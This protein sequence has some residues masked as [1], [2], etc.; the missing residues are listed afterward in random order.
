MKR[1]A[2]K[3]VAFILLLSFLSVAII[4]TIRISKRDTQFKATQ[5][6]LKMMLQVQASALNDGYFSWT[7]LRRLVEE[8]KMSEAQILLND[9]FEIYPFIK[10]ISIRRGDPPAKGYDIIGTDAALD[11]VFGLKDDYGFNPLPGWV[12]VASIKAQDLL[13]ALQSGRKLVVDPAKGHEL[14]YSLKADYED[15]LLNWLDYLFIITMTMAIGYSVSAW[16]WRKS[17]FFYE[18]KGLESIIFLFEQTEQL[19]ANHSRR[20]AVLTLYLGDKMGYKGRRL[21]NLYTAG[22]LHD[23]GKISVPSTLLLKNGPLT[24]SEQQAVAAHPIISARILK[25]FKELTHLSN[26]VLYH[27]E[28]MDGSG[29]PEGLAGADIPE[30]SRIIAVVDVFEALVGERPYRD[31]VEPK[32]AFETLRLMPLDQSIVD[33]LIASYQ[34]FKKFQPPK[35]ALE[36]HHNLEKI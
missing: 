1:Y 26:I 7:E 20:V 16:L 6:G 21:R 25:N 8:N 11:L 5:I 13:D 18:T 29:Y 17:V 24:K 2:F 15:P 23:I 4:T 32:E 31:P 12:G 9:V 30:E 27:H 35:W 34:D 3:T 22:L 36:Y 33:I 28:R 19:S 14:A 10:E